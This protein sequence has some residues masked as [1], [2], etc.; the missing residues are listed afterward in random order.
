[1]RNLLNEK[2]QNKLFGRL[3][4]TTEKFVDIDDIRNKTVLNI[5]CGFGW[6][7]LWGLKNGVRKMIGMDI[8]EESLLAAKSI[9]NNKVSFIVG[10]ALSLPVKDES[11][12]T[13]TSWEVIEHIPKNTERNMFQEANRVLK[14]GGSF[15]LSTPN[16]AIWSN[17]LDPAWWF[18]GHR[19][20]SIN[21]LT[22][23]SKQHGFKIET[24]CVK[25]GFYE[26]LGMINLYI[27]KW[28]FRRNMVFEK[29]FRTKINREYTDLS[30]G[31][32]TLFIKF[33]KC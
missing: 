13:V 4:F 27:S 9:N 11:F 32:A 25:G 31:F 21:K 2:P 10:S 24:H 28:V 12:D 1:M 15:Y 20:Y 19:H 26:M 33:I 6:F 16:N 22:N 8:N 23:I 29:W 17:I 14:K 7:E 18:I 3:F 30:K 5:G